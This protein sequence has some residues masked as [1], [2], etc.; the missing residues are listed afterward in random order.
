MMK[1]RLDNN[2]IDRIALVYFGTEIK[3]LGHIWLGAVCDE[4]Q[5][6]Q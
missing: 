4:N 3:L 1:T 6:G 5:A 2:V